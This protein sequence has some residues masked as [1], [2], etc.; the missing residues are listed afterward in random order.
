MSMCVRMYVSLL[1]I[2]MFVCVYK[3][4]QV[5]VCQCHAMRLNNAS[6]LFCLLIIHYHSVI[7]WYFIN[8]NIDDAAVALGF[9][10]SFVSSAHVLARFGRVCC[11]VFQF[12]L[13]SRSDSC[14]VDSL[15]HSLSRTTSCLSQAWPGVCVSVCLKMRFCACLVLARC[16]VSLKESIEFQQF[17]LWFA[18]SRSDDSVLTLHLL[19]MQ[20]CFTCLQ[21]ICQKKF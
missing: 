16:W 10:S 8:E 1:F 3:Y 20:G 13:P 4:F 14:R 18:F 5:S 2:R 9:N 15:S 12:L 21:I 17:V 7:L 6:R 19:F 11:S